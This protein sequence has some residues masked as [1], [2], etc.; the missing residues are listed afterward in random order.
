MTTRRQSEIAR[1][2]RA[3]APM[4]PLADFNAVLAAATARHLKHLP[5]AIALWQALGAHVRHAHTDYDALLEEGYDREAARHFSAAA[6]NAVLAGWGC[7]RRIDA[8]TPD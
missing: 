4:M 1:Q 5:P 6:M 2:L 7:H 8:D 3:L